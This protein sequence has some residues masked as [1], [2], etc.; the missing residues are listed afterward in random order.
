MTDAVPYEVEILDEGLRNSALGQTTVSNW[1]LIEDMIETDEAIYF[2]NK[3]GLYSA[4]RKR[5]FAS[6]EE[7]KDFLALAKQY[8]ADATLPK[9]PTFEDAG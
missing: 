7:M 3:F 4:V 8:W 6:D 9:P 5:G 1:K 2:R